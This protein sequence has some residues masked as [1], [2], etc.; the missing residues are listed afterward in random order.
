MEVL[1]ERVATD[2]I[3]TQE[4]HL[5]SP[6]QAALLKLLTAPAVVTPQLAAASASA[7]ARFSYE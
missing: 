3:E 6:E 2:I 1:A 4:L 7:R 5:T